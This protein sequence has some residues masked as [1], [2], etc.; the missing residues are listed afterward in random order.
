M[1]IKYGMLIDKDVDLVSVEDNTLLEGKVT[2]AGLI[3]SKPAI[4]ELTIAE[5]ARL[6]RE[7][8][9]MNIDAIARAR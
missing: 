5:A 8:H 1:H 4:L 7:L 9:A 3:G 2:L 6:Y